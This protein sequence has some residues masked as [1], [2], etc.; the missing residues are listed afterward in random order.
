[1]NVYTLNK[2][3]LSMIDRPTL[4][5]FT[6]VA[7]IMLLPAWHS[8]LT[9]ACKMALWPGKKIFIKN[10]LLFQSAYVPVFFL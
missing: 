3:V 9:P 10:I 1:M 8:G 7:L 6:D 5:I 2:K 4:C